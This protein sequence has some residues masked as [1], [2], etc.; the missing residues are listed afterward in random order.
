MRGE[1]AGATPL[2][3]RQ[4]AA[5]LLR[6]RYGAFGVTAARRRGVFTSVSFCCAIAA[7]GRIAQQKDTVAKSHRRAERSSRA[8]RLAQRLP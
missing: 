8:K 4:A 6:I 5:P 7:A 1:G 3:R 2:K